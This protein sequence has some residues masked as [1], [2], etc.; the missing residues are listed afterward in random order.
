MD[1]DAIEFSKDSTEE[2]CWKEHKGYARSY[3]QIREAAFESVMAF[4][5]RRELSESSLLLYQVPKE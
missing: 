1:L 4:T 2:I 5:K 3:K